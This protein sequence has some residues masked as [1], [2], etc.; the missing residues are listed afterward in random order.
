LSPVALER[1]VV[2]QNT[3]AQVLLNTPR[4]LPALPGRISKLLSIHSQLVVAQTPDRRTIFH[5][6]QMMSLHV[7]GRGKIVSECSPSLAPRRLGCWTWRP[8]AR[9]LQPGQR[10]S[11]SASV[12]DR[13][14]SGSRE[15]SGSPKRSMCQTP[16]GARCLRQH[17]TDRLTTLT[18]SC[19]LLPF[20]CDIGCLPVL[21]I[22]GGGYQI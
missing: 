15:W 14:S 8:E 17:A 13:A 19:A 1:P 22:D 3:A 20:Q 9:P 21:W 7:Q 5:C 4:W 10:A 16:R 11:K 2:R 12:L 6:V 18:I